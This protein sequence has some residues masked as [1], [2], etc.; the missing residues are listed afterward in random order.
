MSDNVT[1]LR[2]PDGTFPKGRSG[3][4]SGK[5]KGGQAIEELQSVN[6]ELFDAALKKNVPPAIKLHKWLL[7][8]GQSLTPKEALQCIELAYKYGMK[9]EKGASNAAPDLDFSDWSEDKKQ[10][11]IDLLSSTANDTLS[12]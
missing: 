3:N 2:N 8:K 9:A 5:S 1:P 7:E 10:A 11:I 4:P 12:K 6:K